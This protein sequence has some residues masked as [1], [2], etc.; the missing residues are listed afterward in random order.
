MKKE[1]ITRTKEQEKRII[2]YIISSGYKNISQ[3]AQDVGMERQNVWARIKGKT[4]PDIRMLLK[5]AKVLH[6]SIDQ[7]IQLFYPAEWN[8]YKG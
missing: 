1:S 7:L 2:N 6:S 8:Q 4:D 5:W 3:F